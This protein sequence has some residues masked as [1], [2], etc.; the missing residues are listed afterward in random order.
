[1]VV[2]GPGYI[3][4]LIDGDGEVTVIPDID[5]LGD[6]FGT[7]DGDGLYNNVCDVG[8]TFDYSPRGI[9]DPQSD[10]FQVQFE[11]LMVFALNFGE[12]DP[13]LK[14]DGGEVPTL[15]WERLDEITWV[16]ALLEE[17]TNL[18]GV[19]LTA[20]LPAGVSCQIAGGA[21]L[22]EQDAPVFLRN[23][24]ANGLDAGLATIGFGEAIAGHGELLRVTTSVPVAGLEAKVAARDLG[25]QELLV[26]LPQVTGAPVPQAHA[27][28]QNFPN[29]F[30]P[31]TTIVFALPRDERARLAVYTVEG[32]LVCTLLDEELAA[33]R[34]EVLWRGRDA[35]GRVLP[36]G[37]YLC[38]VRALGE[39]GVRLRPQL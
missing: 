18:K 10:G 35:E 6:C 23:I 33:G 3:R 21:L 24:A 4:T 22:A 8:P 16:L 32:R 5:T 17:C 12:V 37:N 25:N 19:H 38:R 27:L 34:H 7:V 36:S 31:A 30:N 9:P 1:M 28:A 15:R 29:P 39:S 13:T 26:E 11:D 20:E 2:S 14:F